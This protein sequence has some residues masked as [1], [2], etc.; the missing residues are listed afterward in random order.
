MSPL[1]SLGRLVQHDPRS[2]EYPA[3]RAPALRSTLHKRHVGPWDQGQTGSCTAHAAFGLLVTD[4]YT[5]PGFRPTEKRIRTAYEWETRHDG[6]PGV[7]PPDDTGSSGL[8]AAKYLKHEGWISGYRHAFG[9]QHALEALVLGP[10]IVGVNWYDGFDSPDSNGFVRVS[11]DVRGGHE[12]ELV[13][14]DVELGHV[15]ACNS[16]GKSWGDGGY[17]SFSFDDL[18]RLLSEDGDCTTVSVQ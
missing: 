18:G 8:A 17:F 14:L 11:G 2:L 7:Y 3:E 9:L 6:L 16:W 13:G 10:V 1:P 5:R 15:R 4:P 12:F